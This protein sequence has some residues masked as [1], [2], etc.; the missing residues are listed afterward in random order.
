MHRIRENILRF[1]F[2][3][4]SDRWLAVLRIGVGLQVV[5]YTLSL[6]RDWNHFFDARS[7]GLVSRDL[8]EAVLSVDGP[9]I[10]RLGWLVV[11]ASHIGVSES[12]TLLLVWIG[13]LAAGCFLLVG[14]FCRPAAILAWFLYLSATKSAQLLSYGMDNLTTTALFYLMLLPLPD[15]A[16]LDARIR[17]SASHDPNSLAFFGACYRSTSVL[18]IFLV[19]SPKRSAKDGGMV[20]ISGAHSIGHHLPI[21]RP[22]YL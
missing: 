15:T 21:S 19:G 22:T 18:S 3:A 16:S 5:L 13:L 2:P 14:L 11:L 9:L 17:K 7:Y 1:W 12:A 20:L 4:V 10:P 6:R 8:S